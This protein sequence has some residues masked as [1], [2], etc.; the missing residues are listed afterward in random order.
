[1]RPDPKASYPLQPEATYQPAGN[2][3]LNQRV[4]CD[5]GGW[6]RHHRAGTDD[7]DETV[8]P[9]DRVCPTCPTHQAYSTYRTYR[10][11]PNVYRQ[12]PSRQVGSAGRS[13]CADAEAPTRPVSV[14][15][16]V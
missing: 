4:D 12:A 5:G 1:M 11:Y 6:G 7:Q 10:T 2:V 15:P 13:V 3:G 9:A 8:C 14:M 16:P